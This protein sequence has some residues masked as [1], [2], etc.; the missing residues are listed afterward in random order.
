MNDAIIIG[1]IGAAV[2]TVLTLFISA[3]RFSGRLIVVESER[4][5]WQRKAETF[6]ERLRE[7]EPREARFRQALGY[8]ANS[9]TWQPPAKGAKSS[10]F[11][12]R[13]RIAE[14]A[15]TYDDRYKAFEDAITAHK[16]QAVAAE[17][18]HSW[19]VIGNPDA[20]AQSFGAKAKESA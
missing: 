20:I 2:G 17:F 16:S 18:P 3:W 14:L 15:L 1:C 9:D 11:H 10:A 4:D 13:G 6:A 7:V 12:D 8:Y 19:R 5:D